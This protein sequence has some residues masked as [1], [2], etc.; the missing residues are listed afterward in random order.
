MLILGELMKT[1]HRN[2]LFGIPQIHERKRIAEVVLSYK[3]PAVELRPVYL[4]RLLGRIL[5]AGA[6]ILT[7]N[8]SIVGEK[9]KHDPFR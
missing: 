2:V 4:Q 8:R 9:V 1:Q 6:D 7:A 3:M 5:D